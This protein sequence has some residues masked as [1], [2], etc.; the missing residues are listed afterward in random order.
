[1]VIAFLSIENKERKF[2]FFEK[3]FLLADIS[4]DITLNIPLFTLSNIE[5]DFVDCHIY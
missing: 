3:I 1:M 4:I 5:I 2:E